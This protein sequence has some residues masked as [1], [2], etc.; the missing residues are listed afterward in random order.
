MELAKDEIIQKYGKNCGHCNRNK[1]LP[2][3]YE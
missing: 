1:L 2:C 3:S